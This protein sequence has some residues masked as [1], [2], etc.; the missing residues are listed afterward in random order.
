M[1]KSVKRTDFL[2]VHVSGMTKACPSSEPSR[3]ACVTCW[4][5][6]SK[7]SAPRLSPTLSAS[8]RQT[9]WPWCRGQCLHASRLKSFLGRF[10][11]H[12]H[13]QLDKACQPIGGCSCTLQPYLK[14]TAYLPF[15]VP[16]SLK[17]ARWPEH[18]KPSCHPHTLVL[19][20]IAQLHWYFGHFCTASTKP[21]SASELVSAHCVLP[22]TSYINIFSQPR[23]VQRPHFD[24]NLLRIPP[25][26]H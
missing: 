17:Q 8:R 25:A 20:F 4:R 11:S 18:I 22:H 6:R 3:M 21:D 24:S 10:R 9:C 26:T 16:W 1:I 2:T 7:A 14:T 23:I 5:R 13:K 12:Y 15:I 19:L